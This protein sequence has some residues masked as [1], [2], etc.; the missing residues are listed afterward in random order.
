MVAMTAQ[1]EATFDGALKS[2]LACGPNAQH[3]AKELIRAVAGHAITDAVM[4]D[5][6][7]RI[8]RMR[9]SA[10]GKEGMTAFLEKRK[11][12]WVKGE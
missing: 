2:L 6:A 9:A 3:E 5:T 7:G 11:P 12:N 8:A 10:E 4:E 1:L